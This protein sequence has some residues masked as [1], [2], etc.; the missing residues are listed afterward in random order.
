MNTARDL[1]ELRTSGSRVSCLEG[2]STIQ[3]R[4]NVFRVLP[5]AVRG[6][7]GAKLRASSGGQFGR[8]PANGRSAERISAD[9][10][11]DRPALLLRLWWRG[12]RRGMAIR[13][14]GLRIARAV[15]SGLLPRGNPL[16]HCRREMPPAGSVHRPA[17]CATS[18]CLVP[19]LL[20]DP[21]SAPS[22]PSS[23]PSLHT[24][25]HRHQLTRILGVPSASPPCLR[26]YMGETAKS[27][28]LAGRTPSFHT[29][30]AAQIPSG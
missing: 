10:A 22:S 15:A 8:P 2:S 26:N 11:V 18:T 25:L 9:A 24:P 5:A 27:R 30:T 14:G 4:C 7:W 20:R 16:A 1:F 17:T 6:R 19:Q 12:G 21:R 28:I 3:S 13:R 23:A 29:E